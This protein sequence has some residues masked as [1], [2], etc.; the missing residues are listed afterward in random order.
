MNLWKQ[1][2]T[3]PKIFIGCAIVSYGSLREYGR[4]KIKGQL[5]IVLL[6][7]NLL[8]VWVV[9]LLAFL[10]ALTFL[11]KRAS[12]KKFQCFPMYFF[13]PLTNFFTLLVNF[14]YGLTF[15]RKRPRS[16]K[17]LSV[18]FTCCPSLFSTILPRTLFTEQSTTRRPLY[19]PIMAI[20]L[21]WRALYYY[22]QVGQGIPTDRQCT[23]CSV[24]FL[25]L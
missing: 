20:I 15:L 17:M 16:Q 18:L 8:E 24:T 3:C 13:T 11:G 5:L 4:V 19:M 25:E 23:R 21:L 7:K 1:W 12:S 10:Y 9:M 22:C 6:R 14:L 2:Q